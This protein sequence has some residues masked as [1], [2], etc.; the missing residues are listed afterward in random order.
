METAVFCICGTPPPASRAKT[1]RISLAITLPILLV[2]FASALGSLNYA[3]GNDAYLAQAGATVDSRQERVDKA[4]KD[5]KQYMASTYPDSRKFDVF[6]RSFNV[7]VTSEFDDTCVAAIP[8]PDVTLNPLD[9]E[10]YECK[11]KSAVVNVI[12]YRVIQYVHVSLAT[13]GANN[14]APRSKLRGIC[15]I[16][17]SRQPYFAKATKG[18]TH[19]FIPAASCGVFGEVE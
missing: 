11:G 7:K 1:Y 15:G 19:A 14:E 6:K 12:Q 10:S 18:S 17:R 8:K 5:A 13:N 16:L 2:G 3:T 4:C 9:P